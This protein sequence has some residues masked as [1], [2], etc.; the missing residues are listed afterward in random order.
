MSTVSVVMSTNKFIEAF[1]IIWILPDFWSL[2][3][4]IYRFF[5]NFN[6]Y[7]LKSVKYFLSSASDSR[8]STRKKGNSSPLFAG[9]CSGLNIRVDHV[10]NSSYKLPRSPCHICSVSRKTLKSAV[11]HFAVLQKLLFIQLA[12]H[13]DV[14]W[15]RRKT[16]NSTYNIKTRAGILQRKNSVQIEVVDA[17]NADLIRV[18]FQIALNVLSIFICCNCKWKLFGYTLTGL[19]KC[20]GFLKY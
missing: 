20:W 10:W 12:F 17:E 5:K 8:P 7:L 3:F 9:N 4:E 15:A 14:R 11:H 1:G 16:F 2:K 19:L 18:A 13:V 6:P